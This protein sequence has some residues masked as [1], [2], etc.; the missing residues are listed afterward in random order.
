MLRDGVELACRAPSLHNSQPWRWVVDRGTLHLFADRA[1]LLPGA[2]S[3]GR[4]LLLSCGAALDHL[5]V[6]MAASGWETIVGR[7]PDPQE[8]DHLAA[9]TFRRS[10]TVTDAQR[11]RADAILRR[12]T[13]RSPY[14]VPANWPELEPRLLSSVVSHDVLADVVQDS[15][16]PTLALASRLT[17]TLREYDEVYQAELEWYTSPYAVGEGI[18]PTA[19]PAGSEAR[20]T[21]V[22]RFFPSGAR[23][24]Q[25]HGIGDDRSKILVLST[26]DGTDRIDVLRCG[27]ALSG[28]LLE[29]TLAGLASCT[30]THL[31]E[32]T[33]HR[34]VIRSV[35]RAGGSPQVLI[36]FGSAATVTEPQPMT[37]RR[38]L[39]DVLR[40]V[41]T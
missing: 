41:P 23:D 38:P 40:G 18:P 8:P 3:A 1:R 27:E 32:S 25:H 6:A 11:R 4:D 15:E 14:E 20:H 17:E 21:D 39:A 7:L 2:D 36:R 37:P 22:T 9:M 16:R 28:V 26:H 33:L 5:R 35:T 34:D 19:L 12:R 31:T 10:E 29:G 30:L 13:D 24:D